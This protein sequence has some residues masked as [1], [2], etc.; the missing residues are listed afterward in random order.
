MAQLTSRHLKKTVNAQDGTVDAFVKRKER[1]I[2]RL[3][4]SYVLRVESLLSKAKT[5]QADLIAL[6]EALNLADQMSTLIA[7]AGLEDLVDDFLDDFEPLTRQAL[8][9]FK[10]LPGFNKKDPL[11]GIDETHLDAWMA[12]SERL[13]RRR[14]DQSLVAPLQESFLQ[15]AFGQLPRKLIVQNIVQRGTQLR[16]DQVVVAVESSFRDYQRE[17][18]VLK[19]QDLL[20]DNPIYQ[21]SGPNDSIISDQCLFM[22]EHDPHGVPGMLYQDEITVDLHEKLRDNPLIHG[23]HP[24]CRHK[25]MPVT[26]E[27]ALDQ[28][29]EP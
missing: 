24:R 5:D 6:G 22:L 4:A 3:F 1:D 10:N 25:W 2:R 18:T 23:G 17:V 14:V 16:Q 29:F 11:G 20:G 8:Q 21:Y 27:Y 13:V 15:A 7:D 19:A 12:F 26:K 9:Y 28:G